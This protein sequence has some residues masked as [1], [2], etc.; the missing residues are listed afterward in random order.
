VDVDYFKG[1]NDTWGHHAGDLALVHVARLIKRLL[2]ESDLCGRIGGEEFCLLLPETRLEEA[3]EVAER[4][5]HQ[6]AAEA[7]AI[8]AEQQIPLS[9]SLGLASS[10]E[11]GCYQIEHLQTIADRRLYLAKQNGRNQACWQD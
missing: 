2:R 1:V 4:I 7:L 10:E 8:S 3:V 5:R 9:A 11:Q 6:L